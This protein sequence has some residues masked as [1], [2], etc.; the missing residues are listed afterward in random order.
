MITWKLKRNHHGK[1]YC[2]HSSKTRDK[3]RKYTCK[4]IVAKE[5]ISFFYNNVHKSTWMGLYSLIW[6]TGDPTSICQS[7]CLHSWSLTGRCALLRHGWG[8]QGFLRGILESYLLVDPNHLV[9]PNS[10]W[11][12]RGGM[13]GECGCGTRWQLC[14]GDSL[15]P[16]P[17][18]DVPWKLFS[19]WAWSWRK[20][21]KFIDKF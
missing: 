16:A 13:V 2:Q 18:A 1:K 3:L 8:K 6:N 19:S 14:P 7:P 5:L 12:L 9:M 10:E 4:Y 15:W 21:F 17:N 11:C 20:L